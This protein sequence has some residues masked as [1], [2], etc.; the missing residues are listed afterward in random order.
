MA[1]TAD[2][3]HN[4]NLVLVY[5]NAEMS[6]ETSIEQSCMLSVLTLHCQIR[7]T[8]GSLLLRLCVTGMDQRN[9][10]AQTAFEILCT[11]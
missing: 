8:A 7:K 5:S 11:T 6:A 1:A 2:L 9:Q 10:L 3:L 4:R